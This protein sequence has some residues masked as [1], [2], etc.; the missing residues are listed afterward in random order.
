[1]V[2]IE[3]V[4]DT[5]VGTEVACNTNAGQPPGAAAAAESRVKKSRGYSITMFDYEEEGE[6][7]MTQRERLE[8][9][10]YEYLVYQVERCPKTQ[11]LHLQAFIY[12]SN[13]RVWPKKRYP[14]AHIEPARSFTALM[15]YCGKEETRVEGPWEFGTKPAM[16]KRNDLEKLARSVVE[17]GKTASEVAMADPVV[18]LRYHRGLTYLESISYKERT[19]KPRVL[20]LWGETGAGKTFY[21]W[22]L[23]GTKYIKDGTKWWDGYS[24]QD[25]III[26]DFDGRWPVRDLLRLLDHYPYQGEKK[27]GYVPVNSGTIVITCDE[28]PSGFWTSKVCSQMLRRIDEVKEMRKP[29][30]RDGP[31][32]G[33][34]EFDPDP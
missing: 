31:I 9:D 16:G 19:T 5:E 23:P 17:G 2:R 24:Q 30:E 13:A 12:Y 32:L 20:W 8:T 4:D 27:G 15:R 3:E 22:S 1:M 21:A 33:D 28:P 26:D 14:R 10:D 11:R 25:V 7:G 34:D 6:D 29:R 18:G